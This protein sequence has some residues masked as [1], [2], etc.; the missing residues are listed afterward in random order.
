VDIRFDALSNSPTGNDYAAN[1]AAL[2]GRDI[3]GNPA[4]QQELCRIIRH[5]G[6]GIVWG[7]TTDPASASNDSAPS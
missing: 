3:G 7:G 2:L 4:E 5:L 1:T 6:S